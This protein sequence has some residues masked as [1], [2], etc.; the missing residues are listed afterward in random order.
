M[1]HGAISIILAASA[2]GLSIANNYAARAR[3]PGSAHILK[4]LTEHGL[5]AAPKSYAIVEMS[6]PRLLLVTDGAAIQ[7]MQITTWTA[8]AAAI[9]LA[10]HAL[11]RR[12][13][14]QYPSGALVLA[15][16]A[17]ALFNLPLAFV[18][19]F[20]SALSGIWIRRRGE[21]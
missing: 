17:I 12:E 7:L 6:E 1:K 11:W 18:T 16:L 14:D 3:I 15:S 10:L 8:A 13:P 21:V 2:L 19:A 5:V 9:A 4:W 20:G